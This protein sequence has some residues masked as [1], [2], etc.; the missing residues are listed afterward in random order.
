MKEPGLSSNVEITY[1]D[2]LNEAKSP[3]HDISI[4]FIDT[5]KSQY[6]FIPRRIR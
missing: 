2:V 6:H 4:L 1:G 3:T 5:L